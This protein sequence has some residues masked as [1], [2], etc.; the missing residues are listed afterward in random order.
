MAGDPCHITFTGVPVDVHAISIDKITLNALNNGKQRVAA[1]KSAQSSADYTA[2][3]WLAIPPAHQGYAPTTK[4]H[5]VLAVITDAGEI[6]PLED[7]EWK[8]VRSLQYGAEQKE[9]G[10]RRDWNII[11]LNLS[12]EDLMVTIYGT[13]TSTSCIPDGTA[14]GFK[15]RRI[16]LSVVG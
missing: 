3:D 1:I 7:T 6:D 10:Y 2:G 14:C 12:G 16:A 13:T 11:L 15:V 9:T 5:L 8:I 4:H